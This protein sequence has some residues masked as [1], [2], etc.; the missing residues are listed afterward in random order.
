MRYGSPGYPY[1]GSHT[2]IYY[3]DIYSSTA[4]LVIALIP[5][6]ERTSDSRVCR[7]LYTLKQN[8]ALRF[9][10]GLLFFLSTF[11]QNLLATSDF[12]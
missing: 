2:S 6:L 1:T 7:A 11:A 12:E 8:R 9:S 10:Q 3:I 4:S 5:F